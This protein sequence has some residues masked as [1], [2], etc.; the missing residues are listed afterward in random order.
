M[1][2]SGGADPEN[3]TGGGSEA[4]FDIA[5]A[6]VIDYA[7]GG[8]CGRCINWHASNSGLATDVGRDR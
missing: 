6:I 1:S 7:S 8:V 4:P 3:Y 5:L 2:A